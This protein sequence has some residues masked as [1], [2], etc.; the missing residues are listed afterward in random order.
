MNA[1]ETWYEIL[2][3][4]E[5]ASADE[6]R[7]AYFE[8]ARL[9]H[10]DTNPGKIAKERFLQ[11][12]EAYETLSNPEK[13]KKYDESGKGSKK[14]KPQVELTLLSSAI[15]IPRLY[16][17]QLFYV[18]LELKG[19]IKPENLK[20]PAANICL[21][22]DCSTSMKGSRIS[23]V[24]ENIL[25]FIETLKPEDTLSVVTFNDRAELVL[26]PTK[27]R[28][29]GAIHDRIENF[30]CL[31]GTEIFRGVKAAADL[32]WGSATDG[33]IRQIFLLTDGHTYGDEDSCY[34]IAQKL[35]SKGITINTL[36]IGSEWNDIFLDKLARIT[37]GS[38]TF[39]STH[40]DLK[41]YFENLS[42]SISIVAAN[43]VSIEFRSDEGVELNSI[44]RLQPN[45]GQLLLEYPIPLGEIYQNRKSTFLLTYTINPLNENVKTITLGKG[46][47]VFE[48]IQTPGMKARV[49]VII[50]LPVTE[51]MENENPPQEI[52]EA[53]SGINIYQMQEKTNMD[54]NNGN[55][56]Q[57]VDRL[58]H[59]STQLLKMGKLGLA[60]RAQK[61]AELL[62]TSRKYSLDGD[63]QLK[64]GTRALLSPELKK[65]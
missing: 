23:M 55:I 60:K 27:V 26:S 47:I 65:R 38:S 45:I 28:D 22:V 24:K 4:S 2:E 44:Y 33:V 63:K 17:T 36:G 43:N 34:E 29:I 53:L 12:Q 57:A 39:I 30:Q 13:R 49:P 10:P 58:G 14:E 37:G 21:L 7:S 11:I 1:G 64:Y 51:Q 3:I 50:S 6:I 41:K 59:M 8:Q 31:G 40:N 61:E 5:E 52:I 62:K 9:F 46:K 54:V 48:P 56:E 15:K 32:F 25:S 35:N 42:T 19:L 20:T 16:E 18:I